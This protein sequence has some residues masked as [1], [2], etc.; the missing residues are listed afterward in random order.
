MQDSLGVFLIPLVLKLL[1]TNLLAVTCIAPQS[2]HLLVEQQCSV[3]RSDFE[4]SAPNF[5]FFS[6]ENSS[7]VAAVFPDFNYVLQE[8]KEVPGFTLEL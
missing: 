3:E 6:A 2:L 5:V 1:K 7:K 4:C 8:Q